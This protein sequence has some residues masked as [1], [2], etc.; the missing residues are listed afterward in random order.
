MLINGFYFIRY[1]KI[2]AKMLQV[3]CNKIIFNMDPQLQNKSLPI[4]QNQEKR[5][6]SGQG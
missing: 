5:N 3:L 4:P 6:L 1:K 2:P